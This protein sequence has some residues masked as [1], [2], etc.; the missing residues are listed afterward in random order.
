ME[1]KRVEKVIPMFDDLIRTFQMLYPEKK[2][3][4]A[5]GSVRDIYLGIEPKDIDMYFLGLDWSK[6]NKIKFK[7]KLDASQ[8]Y[9]EVWDANLPWHKYERFLIM[10]IVCKTVKELSDKKIEVQFM[11]F[12]V[13]SCEK[14]L[15]TFDWEMCIF[16][17]EPGCMIASQ[18]AL[19]LCDKIKLYNKT[20]IN[21]K[22]PV[23][24]LCNVQF[25]VSNL[26]RGFKFESRY[27]IKLNYGSILKLCKAVIEQDTME[28]KNGKMEEWLIN[29]LKKYGTNV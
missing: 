15:E 9:Y 11:G 26:R 3:V 27:P 6:E 22:P 5:G 10:S 8:L 23:M 14:L 25:P 20:D 29:Q 13:D 19:D 18:E 28:S 4:I 17:Y 24:K 21:Y 2:L 12:P 7:Q 16:S 1:L